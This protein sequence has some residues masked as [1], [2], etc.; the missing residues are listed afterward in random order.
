MSVEDFP[1]RDGPLTGRTLHRVNFDPNQDSDS[2]VGEDF[3]TTTTPSAFDASRQG[4]QGENE[5]GSL[6]D[7]E[8]I[9]R[10]MEQRG[11]PRLI[12]RNGRILVVRVGPVK[13]H[14]DVIDVSDA[15]YE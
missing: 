15:V 9:D 6:F 2:D 1:L 5:N 4:R 8:P 10:V 14:L 3:F 13:N 11:I 7:D 12:S